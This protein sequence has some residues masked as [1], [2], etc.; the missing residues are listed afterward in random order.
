MYY[1]EWA[2]TQEEKE[3]INKTKMSLLFVKGKPWVK[4]SSEWDVT[5]GSFDGA[6]TC[7]LVGLFMLNQLQQTNL[8]LGLYR[9]DGLGV[10]NLKGRPL[11][12]K[13]QEIQQIFRQHNLRVTITANLEATDFLDIFLDLRSEK[14]RVFTKEGDTPTYVHHQSNHPPNVLKNIGPAVNRRLSSLSANN[15]LFNQAKPLYQDALRRS[16]HDHDLKF[17]EEVVEE[18]RSKRRRKRQ[19]IWWNPPFSMNVKTNIGAKF[20][21]LIKKCFPKDGP[22]GKAFNRSNL[23]LSYSTMPNMKQ[24]IAAHNRKVLAEV[25]PPIPVEDPPEAK[26]CNC[27]RRKLEEMGGCPLKGKCLI[28]NV[29]YQAVVVETKV[30]GQEEVEKYV[31]CTT[32]FKTRWRHHDKSFNNPDYKHETVLS[33]HIWEC[34]SRGSTW[35]VKWKILDRGQPFNPVTNVCKLCVR[36]QFYILRKPNLATLNHRQEIGTFCPHIRSSL[37]RN[38]KK[39]KVPD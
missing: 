1:I 8:N 22:L 15:D 5:M 35:K 33:T 30:D 12:A 16:K 11:E 23:K 14:Y 6:E 18:G 37:L 36:E 2:E 10:T 26:T 28:T 39:V 27:S 17:N 3:V 29:V 21:A 38:I 19:I 4:R 31:G 20:L 24:I 34:K 25:K 9:D 32:D 13:R 7:E